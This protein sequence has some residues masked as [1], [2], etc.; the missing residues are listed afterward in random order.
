VREL[1]EHDVC[2]FFAFRI[3]V[4]RNVVGEACRLEEP[5]TFC[6]GIKYLFQSVLLEITMVVERILG[7][8]FAQRALERDAKAGEVFMNCRA[9]LRCAK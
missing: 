8:A 2:C 9:W 6:R 1:V 7:G 3:A 5:A 4:H